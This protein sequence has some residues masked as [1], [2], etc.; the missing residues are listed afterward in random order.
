[1]EFVIRTEKSV[2]DKFDSIFQI[3]NI[4]QYAKDYD[5]MGEWCVK[6]HGAV[7]SFSVQIFANLKC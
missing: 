4:V 7:R 3:Q 6:Q 1:M 5:S 2:L